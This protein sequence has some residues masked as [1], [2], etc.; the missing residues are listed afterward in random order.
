MRVSRPRGIIRPMAEGSW[1]G[2]AAALGAWHPNAG[3]DPQLHC[4]PSACLLLGSREGLGEGARVGC[5]GRWLAEERAVWVLCTPP[6]A[7]GSGCHRRG[8][9]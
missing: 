9:H 6:S 2:E 1:Q 4:V 5:A 7:L 3:G 8:G